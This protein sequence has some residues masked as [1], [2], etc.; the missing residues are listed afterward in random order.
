[1]LIRKHSYLFFILLFSFSQQAL[2]QDLPKASGD[3]CANPQ[4]ITQ[5]VNCRV[6]VIAAAQIN[7]KG[8]SKQVE[9]PSIGENTTSLVDQTDAPD[10]LG[11]ALNLAGINSNDGEAGDATPAISTNLYALYAAIKGRDPLDPSFYVSHAGLRRLSFTLGQDAAED[12]GSPT[13]KRALLFGAKYLIL[14]KRDASS[15]SNRSDLKNVSTALR[16]A[17]TNFATI[18]DVVEVY[19]FDRLKGSLGYPKGPETMNE[20]MIRFV[21][22]ELSSPGKTAATLQLLSSEHLDEINQMIVDR[23]GT[24]VRLRETSLEAYEKIRRRPQLSFS[25]QTKQRRD[26]GADE[27][28]TGLL[29]DFGVYQRFNVAV[30]GTFDYV[31]SKVIGGD[32]RGGRIAA[33]GYFHLNQ[34]RELF[35]GKDPI[36]LS[37]GG[38]SKW[39]SNTDATHTAQVKLTIPLFDGIELPLSFSVANRSDLINES[40]VRGRFGFTLDLA[41][42]LK[43]VR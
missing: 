15:V 37:F 8:T 43:G 10:V 39:M 20:A 5:W 25:F 21:N 40:K 17:T 41:K 6:D 18:E 32:T 35:G 24:A 9:V 26:S 38:E 12:E 16:D 3:P 28:R 42:L 22:D 23:I 19:I 31:D 30:N 13:E 27:Y 7:Q 34:D 29:L 1:M 33:E 36:V 4:N 11:L 14:N 2:S